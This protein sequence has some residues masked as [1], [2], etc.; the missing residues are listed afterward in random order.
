MRY[1]TVATCTDP[2]CRRLD[3][4]GVVLYDGEDRSEAERAAEESPY[5]T[6]YEIEIEEM[7]GAHR[8]RV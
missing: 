8:D 5:P 3:R 6:G 4:A 1:Q 7:A 2:T